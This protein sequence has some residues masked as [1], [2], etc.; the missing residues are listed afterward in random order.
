MWRH[1]FLR[2][3]LKLVL[4]AV[5]L[6]IILQLVY[7]RPKIIEPYLDMAMPAEKQDPV[8]AKIKDLLVFFD[9]LEKYAID[10]PSLKGNYKTEKA[11]EKFASNDDFMFDKEYLENVLDISDD[12]QIKMTDS[13]TR[14]V[15][16]R[17][18]QLIENYGVTTFGANLT[19]DADWNQYH[20]SKGY[21]LVGGGKYSWLSY[22]VIRQLR[23][24]GSTLP[25][26]LFIPLLTEYEAD[27]C[28]KVLPKYNARCNVFNDTLG[29]DLKKRFNLG[30]FQYKMLALLTLKF[31]LILYLDSDDFPVRNPDYLFDGA[32][33]K[34]TGLVIWP[35]AWARTTNPKFFEIAGKP[36]KERK[37]RWSKFDEKEAERKGTKVKPLEE[38]KFTELRFHDFE[39]ALPDPTLETG[40][41]LVDKTRQLRTLLL[42]LYY[43]VFGP[44]FYYPIMT[45]GSAGEGDKETFIAAAH[46][47][48]EPYYQ[49]EKGM[50]WLGYNREDKNGGEFDSKALG[51]WDPDDSAKPN[52]DDARLL[53]M[54]LSYPKYYPDWLV[55]NH[56][57][58]S[59]TL[60]K[61]VRM[62]PSTY[63]KM[64]YDFDL[65]A[66]QLF[67]MGACANYYGDD[68][69]PVDATE[70]IDKSEFMGPHLAYIAGIKQ[71]PDWCEKVFIPHLKWLK[72]TTEYPDTS[73][74]V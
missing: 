40:Q 10:A 73:V 1:T 71:L 44:N 33:F 15:N 38:Y 60:G 42:A 45:Q 51:H 14:Y 6:I 72:S 25:A 13:H 30:G 53:F 31:E 18:N 74:V 49:T 37:V 9:D 61:D 67:T 34:E 2:H 43:N 64:G 5:L 55:N 65:R 63:K 7:Y 4:I 21:V 17:I 41:L 70:G 26:E 59:K 69:K 52:N 8:K 20:G 54:H 58:V 3:R 48:G 22:L 24:L 28:E 66:L 46:V 11:Y 27:F 68:G 36:V 19:T 32:K 50:A 39:G 57:L 47:L 62:Y 29:A 35:D 56:E 23:A 12:T 16:D